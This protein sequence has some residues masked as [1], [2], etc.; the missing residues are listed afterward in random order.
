MAYVFGINIPLLEIM[1]IMLVLLGLGLILILIEL[2]KL[3]QLLTEEKT[4]INEF[5]SDLARFE[6]D[7]GKTATAQLNDYIKSAISRGISKDQIED[8]LEK[9]GWTK[10]KIDSIM[11]NLP[12]SADPGKPQDKADK[13]TP[14]AQE[15]K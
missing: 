5:E 1:L 7:E 14:K 2:K 6:D 8:V 4:V 10:E 9:R 12:K 13:Q 15:K 3:R 11:A